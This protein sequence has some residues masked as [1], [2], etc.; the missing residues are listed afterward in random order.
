M[1]GVV[2]DLD[3]VVAGAC[4]KIAAMNLQDRC[5]AVTGDF[6]SAVPAVGDAYIMKHIIHDWDDERASV[7]LK[8]M[9]TALAGKRRAGSSCSNR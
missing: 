6:F 5:E 8:N 9:R 1:R 4:A 7:I 2:M 3:H